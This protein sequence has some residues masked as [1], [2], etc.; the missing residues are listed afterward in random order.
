MKNFY[1]LLVK[2]FQV[3]TKHFFLKNIYL[4]VAR[5]LQFSLKA[6]KNKKESSTQEGKRGSVFTE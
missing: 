4:S 6:S 5:G 3:P 1:Y 2:Q